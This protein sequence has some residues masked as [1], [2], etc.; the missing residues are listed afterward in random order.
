MFR[1][2]EDKMMIRFPQN[3]LSPNMALGFQTK[4]VQS[5]LD[6]CFLLYISVHYTVLL[7]CLHWS[8]LTVF[9][10]GMS[11]FAVTLEMFFFFLINMP[12]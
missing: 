5:L 11:C 7:G 9:L 8:R 10:L 2:S 1:E 3:I 6:F 12:H 4:Y